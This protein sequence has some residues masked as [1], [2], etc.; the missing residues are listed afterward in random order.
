MQSLQS[1]DQVGF[2]FAAHGGQR[3]HGC[4]R[5]EGRRHLEQVFLGPG[6]A[7]IY[8]GQ[9]EVFKYAG[10]RFG[11]LL[12]VK[13]PVFFQQGLQVFVSARMPVQP[14]VHLLPLLQR[15]APQGF[16]IIEQ[17]VL[18]GIPHFIQGNVIDDVRQV[19]HFIARREED[20]AI[21]RRIFA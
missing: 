3:R 14:L 6:Q 11:H 19:F 1:R 13:G 15:D 5:D 9:Q 8:L 18:F 10:L 20:M 17:A 2:C 7:L 12:P 21:M 16:G 4:P